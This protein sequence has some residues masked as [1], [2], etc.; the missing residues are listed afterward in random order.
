MPLRRLPHINKRMVIAALKDK[1]YY[2]T[3]TAEL[4]KA[5]QDFSDKLNAIEGILVYESDANFVYIKLVGY[6]VEKI[7][8]IADRHGYLIR[9]F[10]GNNEKHLR[11]TMGPKAMMDD[12]TQI[13]LEAFE[14]A[15]I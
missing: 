3:I 1:E 5:R 6:D 14:A 12:L 15:K 8:A 10:T 2:D 13:M 4:L 9:I 7:K 11:I